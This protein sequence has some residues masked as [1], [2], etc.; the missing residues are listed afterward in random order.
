MVIY[1][2]SAAKHLR[3]EPLPPG[4][5]CP[6]CGRPGGLRSSIFTRYAHLY[7]IPFFPY[8]KPAVT[9]CTH[10]QQAWNDKGLPAEL[11]APVQALKQGSKAPRT[12][13]TG[14]GLVTA[15]ILAGVFFS[16]KDERANKSYLQS[17][18]IGD[19]YTVRVDSVDSAGDPKGPAHY[20][21]LK[22]R[23]VS[24]NSVELVGN[25]YQIDN[26]H[27]LDELN[28]PE[29]Y[30]KEPVYVTRYDLQLMQQKGELTDVDRP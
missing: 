28:K 6:S 12:H 24:G 5:A 7:W 25:D 14:L 19:V 20:S 17:P 30:A 29:N 15:G 22:V 21:L 8:E 9:E 16:A 11:R 10:C 26:S 4:T 13:Y 1:G 3:T 2:T 27:P 18:R 23:G